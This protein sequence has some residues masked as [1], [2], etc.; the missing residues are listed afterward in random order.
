MQDLDQLARELAYEVE[1]LKLEIKNIT[2]ELEGCEVNNCSIIIKRVNDK[3]YYY[4]QWREAGKVKQ[5]YL[6]QVAPGAV[7]DYEQQLLHAQQLQVLRRQ[8]EGQLSY[9]EGVLEALE[10]KASQEKLLENYSFEVYWKDEITA[11]VHVQGSR[12]KVSR[13]VKHPL[14]QLFAAD[15][16]SR[17]QLNEIFELRCWDRNRV[18]IL[19]ILGHYGLDAY[20]PREIVRKTH[21]V[22]YN[23]YIWFR[24][25]GEQLSSKD[26]LV[27]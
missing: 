24:F 9:L 21:G 19:D 11:R 4:S 26:V 17:H 10:A 6:C 14:K 1:L 16:M 2:A 12:V 18:D 25:P 23:D 13:Y 27:R 8:K 15:S 20:T 3:L 7:S 22:S 5:K